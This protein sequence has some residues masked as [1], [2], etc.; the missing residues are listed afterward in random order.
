M[1][2]YMDSM[3]ETWHNNEM[4]DTDNEV[5]WYDKEENGFIG[6]GLRDTV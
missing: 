3:R 4:Y 1:C 5:K 2:L 6:D